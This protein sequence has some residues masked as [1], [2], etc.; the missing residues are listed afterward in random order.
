M[1]A[2][3]GTIDYEKPKE[4]DYSKNSMY[5]L[6]GYES[7]AKNSVEGIYQSS[8]DG[9]DILVNPALARIYGYA[10]PEDLKSSFSPS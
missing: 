8:Q 5:S 1:P 4:S 9:H 6:K 3:M 10:S 7:I 2:A